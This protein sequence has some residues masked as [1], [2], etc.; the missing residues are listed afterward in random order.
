LKIYNNIEDFKSINTV[1][2]IGVFDGV[3]KGHLSVIN[4]VI[5]IAK[6][7]NKESVVF[8]FWP[9]PVM[10]FKPKGDNVRLIN[11]IDEKIELIRATG[12]GHLIVY[13]FNLG[14]SKLNSCNFIEQILVN[15]LHVSTLVV[16]FNHH[17][18]HKREG[19]Y[20]D[21][22]N[23]TKAFNLSLKR[24][25]PY[26]VNKQEI[27]STIIRNELIN[28]NIKTANSFLGYDYFITG[29]VVEGSKIGRSIGFPTANILPGQKFKLIPKDGVYA[30]TIDYENNSYKG[31][32]N[33]GLRPTVNSSSLK[34]SI[35]VH[36]FDFNHIIY[37]KN[38]KI[39]FV[40]RLR[41][42]IKFNNVNELQKQL[43]IDKQSIIN[44]LSR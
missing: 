16:G 29:K 7:E 33:I 11:S 25:N 34:K 23:C 42:E 39:R 1:I 5:E 12:I 28:G 18:G 10:V 37:D 13:P 15:K 40:Q 9:H 27:S 30:V 35:E 31:M 8:T 24:C 19:S 22:L 14:F 38:I 43:N 32:L 4:N 26:L 3:H 6:K 20:D 21:L 44:I 41:D 36:I 2:T 17:F